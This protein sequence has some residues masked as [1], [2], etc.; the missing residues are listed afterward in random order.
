MIILVKSFGLWL[1]QKPQNRARE[2]SNC[3]D[4]SRDECK[5]GMEVSRLAPRKMESFLSVFAMSR[6]AIGR[7]SQELRPIISTYCL[8]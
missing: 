3:G 1:N 5:E 8:V 2:S 6:W 7:G 4:E